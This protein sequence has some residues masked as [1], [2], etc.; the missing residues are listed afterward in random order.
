MSEALARELEAKGD[1][2][3]AARA[4]LA[5]GSHQEAARMYMMAVRPLDAAL[6]LLDGIAMIGADI[7]P[8]DRS[9]VQLAASLMREGGRDD[10]AKLMLGALGGGASFPSAVLKSVALTRAEPA[11]R[12]SVAPSVAPRP[13]SASGSAFVV[14]A[15]QAPSELRATAPP[16]A[17]ATPAPTRTPPAPGPPAARTSATSSAPARSRPP[18]SSAPGTPAPSKDGDRHRAEAGWHAA[19]GAQIEETIRQFIETGRKGA[20]ARVA[21]E[22]GQFERALPWF[23]ELGLNYQAGSCLRSL[24]RPREALTAMLEVPTDDGR[25]RRACFDVI[26]LARETSR[27]DFEVD[28]FL[29]S[30]V[31]QGPVDASECDGFLELAELY[32]AAG[33]AVGARRCAEHVLA[34]RP[35]DVRAKQLV[36]S[37]VARP[38]GGSGSDRPERAAQTGD[39][40]ALPSLDEFIALARKHAPKRPPARH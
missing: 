27:L 21:W 35:D 15:S 23:L 11:R 30:F 19:D 26:G 9:R 6:A 40:E 20:A 14:R 3:G 22:A 12:A 24:G 13:A 37:A 29:T 36:T 7:E 38:R 25:Y 4:F 34:K 16:P 2:E 1:V 18:T 28:R 33:F 31:G 8:A 10:Y 17:A 39:L 32:A 5:A